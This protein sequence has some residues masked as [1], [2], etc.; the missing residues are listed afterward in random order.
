V[1]KLLLLL[2]ITVTGLMLSPYAFGKSIILNSS[3]SVSIRGDI[4]TEMLASVIS[5]LARN[6][7]TV[8]YIYINSGGGDIDSGF[9]ILDYLKSTGK[10]TVCITSYA[11][12]M[13][14]SMFQACDVRLVTPHAQLMQHL[15]SYMIMGKSKSND[16]ERRVIMAK[17]RALDA[18]D[19]KRMGLSVSDFKKRIDFDMWL[20]GSEIIQNK[21][22]DR[23]V[24]VE[25]S[26]ELA[27]KREV[28]ARYTDDGYL[29]KET[30]SSCPI[31]GSPISVEK[32][33]FE[34]TKKNHSRFTQVK[35]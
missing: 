25:C 12:S 3:N 20:F 22:A 28:V 19:A 16:S 11:A 31:I 4:N 17:L 6:K 27:N 24:D 14:F 33:P 18:A 9:Q 29:T 23:M 34:T 35:K 10:K 21:A 2:L 32:I 8:Q 26:S 15:G 30:F 5:Q 7:D 13:A 1:R